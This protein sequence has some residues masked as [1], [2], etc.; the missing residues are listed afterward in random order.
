ME[1]ATMTDKLRVTI[2]AW[3]DGGAIPGEYAMG[4]PADEGHATFGRNRNP[5]IRWSGAPAGTRSF[6]ILCVDPDAP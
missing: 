4:V 6:A 1:E 3:P 5:A 2:D